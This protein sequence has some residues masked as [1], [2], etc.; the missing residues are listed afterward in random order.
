MFAEFFLIC[1]DI[2][3]PSYASPAHGGGPFPSA[4]REYS[5]Q[6]TRE[7]AEPDA[8][9]MGPVASEWVGSKL[10]GSGQG[11]TAAPGDGGRL[12]VLDEPAL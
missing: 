4:G 11:V 5:V 9:W 7:G 2:P 6:Q 3:P 8:A 1:S 12:L 10:E